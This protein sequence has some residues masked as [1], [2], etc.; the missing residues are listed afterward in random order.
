M[1]RWVGNYKHVLWRAV[2]IVIFMKLSPFSVKPFICM[3][4]QHFSDLVKKRNFQFMNRRS[5]VK[6]K[7]HLIIKELQDSNH[8]LATLSWVWGG[9]RS[10]NWHKVKQIWKTTSFSFYI[11]FLYK[12]QPGAGNGFINK[13]Y[14]MLVFMKRTGFLVR[15]TQSFSSCTFCSS[16]QFHIEDPHSTMETTHLMGYS[17]DRAMELIHQSLRFEDS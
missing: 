4:P 16:V 12:P 17:V 2:K 14:E 9:W 6:D 8:I 15:M 1:L 7:R 11:I 13:N 3:P 10:L 5:D